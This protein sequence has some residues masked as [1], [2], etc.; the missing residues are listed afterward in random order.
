MLAQHT[1]G[2]AIVALVSL[3]LAASAAAAQGP[4]RGVHPNTGKGLANV[5][6]TT[7]AQTINPS[8]SIDLAAQVTSGQGGPVPTGMVTFVDESTNE[9][10]GTAALDKTGA[11]S[12]TVTGVFTVG[13]HNIAA[14]YSGD[15]LY[16]A[17]ES[18]PVT[19]E[20][21]KSTTTTAIA[22]ATTTPQS[23]QPLKVTATI[24]AVNP[25][26]TPPS[27]LVT[28]F[29][30]GVSQ[31]D[32]PVVEGTP[33]TATIEITLPASGSHNL[34]AFYSGDD[35][36]DNSTSPVV[37]VTIISKGA[38]VTTVTASPPVLS[39]GGTE[40][41]T[42]TVAPESPKSGSPN[43]TG[44]VSFYDGTSLLGSPVAV[45]LSKG[46]FTAVLTGVK[47]S[48]TAAHTITAVYSGDSNWD[49]STSAPI[50]LEAFLL[51]DT[52]TLAANVSAI[53]PGQSATLT[54]TVT[55]ASPPTAN[56]EPYPT[57]NVTF[58]DG[59]TILATVALAPSTGYS[60]TAVYLIGTLPA[61]KNTITARYAGDLYYKS[62]TS[63]PVTLDVED[64]TIAP[65]PSNPPGNLT[66]VQG[67]S[68]SATFDINGLGGFDN[69][70]QVVCAVPGGIDMT[71]T[72]KPQLVTPPGK[73]V[74]I[75]DTFTTGNA[76]A[77]AVR[78]RPGTN[79]RRAAGASTLAAVLFV[80]VPFGR[81]RR[82]A[83][84]ALHGRLRML[85]LLLPVIFTA[86]GGCGSGAAPSGGTPLGVA[87]LKVTAA[88]NIP[89][90]VVS[91]SVYLTVNVI[92]PS[93]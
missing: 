37:I 3:A 83:R 34:Q 41:L 55:P 39:V 30:D 21:E 20:V 53:A 6:M 70:V 42:A 86:C 76:Q 64:F 92:A 75:V 60:A 10:V 12:T 77:A 22:P 84:R 47:L 36:Y 54:V 27:G 44:T 28:F 14:K 63:N 67:N 52:V 50:T 2:G 5:M 51:P 17:K 9:D 35:N 25:G 82:D 45:N 68:G 58:F 40:T 90:T 32:K 87:T 81:R 48:T 33:S 78:N 38:T 1:F 59:T 11:A 89:N 7:V 74:I 26:A 43:I 72:P 69:Q 88:A 56:V 15:S 91:H 4:N 23:G 24:D 65:D 29:L 16:A 18:L 13:G 8:G 19:I 71:C 31:G 61:G 73:V 49:T 85:A 80:L 79:W 93:N 57:G 62:G 66:I 46:A